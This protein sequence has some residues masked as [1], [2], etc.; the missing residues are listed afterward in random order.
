MSAVP[1]SRRDFVQCSNWKS[2]PGADSTSRYKRASRWV[3]LAGRLV[4]QNHFWEG[5]APPAPMGK[6]HSQGI[7]RGGSLR[8]H[9]HSGG[10]LMKAAVRK[11]ATPRRHTTICNTQ[12]RLVTQ[13]PR[14]RV[15]SLAAV[16][17]A[18]PVVSR[19]AWA[20]AYPTRP[21]RLVVPLPPGG[22]VDALARPWADKIRPLLGTVF[23]DN[24]GGAGG[25]LGAAQVAHARP[26]GYTPSSGRLVSVH[27]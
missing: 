18:L 1:G 13:H 3:E 8:F 17:A 19:F 23:I 20:Q 9:N 22:A 25:S 26:D 10:A 2:V 24:I 4:P 11:A 21:I 14:R 5:T 12:R 6:S 7:R 15:L 27:Q 16:A